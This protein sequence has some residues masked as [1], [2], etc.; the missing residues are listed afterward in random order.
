MYDKYKKIKIDPNA[1]NQDPNKSIKDVSKYINDK[2]KTVFSTQA[3]YN[4]ISNEAKTYEQ[5]KHIRLVSGHNC[6]P[7]TCVKEF[8]IARNNYY[9]V[10]DEHLNK[11]Q[12]P[13]QAYHLI[14][15]FKGKIDPELAHKIG[16][17]FCQILLGDSFQA[18]VST[19]LNTQ[20]THN[21]IL[22][23]AFALDGPYKFKDEYHLYKKLREISNSLSLKYGVELYMG[24]EQTKQSYKHTSWSE[25]ID[26]EH[27]SSYKQQFIEDIKQ[28]ASCESVK[29]Y[30][31]FIQEMESK[32][33][34]CSINKSSTT[35]KKDGMTFR[36]VSL[37][38]S[39]KKEALESKWQTDKQKEDTLNYLKKLREENA[40]KYKKYDTIFV[41][42]WDNL[43]NRLGILKR[44]LLMIK[45]LL[46]QIADD[47]YLPELEEMY[48]SNTNFQSA[49]K[50]LDNVNKAIELLTTYN[51]KTDEGLLIA[52]KETGSAA[53]QARAELNL[54]SEFLANAEEINQQISQFTSLQELL[55]KLNIPLDSIP[56]ST[57][58]PDE[59]KANLAS[60]EPM[61]PK[62]KSRLYQKLHA[63]PY[64]LAVPFSSVTNTEAKEILYFLTAN[65]ENNQPSIPTPSLLLTKE[66]YGA[67]LAKKDL[68]ELVLAKLNTPK[69]S[70]ILSSGNK[71][72][73]NSFVGAY[74]N[75][76]D[77]QQAQQNVFSL[78]HVPSAP[79][80]NP[81][82]INSPKP[83][84]SRPYRATTEQF[85]LVC[86]FKKAYPNLFENINPSLLSAK[87]AQKII[88]Y[89][90]STILEESDYFTSSSNT[91]SLDFTSFSP[92]IQELI[93]EYRLVKSSL[94]EYGLSS[95]SDIDSFQNL[96]K[97][98][99]REL[100]KHS[101]DCKN[102]SDKYKDLKFIQRVIQ[103]ASKTT[104]VYGAGYM[105][106]ASELKETKDS[107]GEPKLD[108]LFE[109]HHKLKSILS[110]TDLSA[111][112]QAP[113]SSTNFIPPTPEIKETLSSIKSV[114]PESYGTLNIDTISE[115]DALM[116][117]HSII[118][119]QEIELE[120]KKILEQEDKLESEETKKHDKQAFELFMQNQLN[121]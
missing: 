106:N 16:L 5:E 2:E 39:Y 78:L 4:Y 91:N 7:E 88:D 63:S 112:S 54:T 50:K 92:D 120:M 87:D 65:N 35:F 13:I 100:Q 68:K 15:S 84:Y 47:Y 82:P 43:G 101:D 107:L 77:S 31:S 62:V 14:S 71:P 55:L 58:S 95:Q 121:N 72:N 110:S 45:N 10:K 66:E 28:A 34:T 40:L 6:D 70:L 114:F 3:A 26:P 60:L 67:V 93:K 44:L 113:I 104:F 17:E 49:F 81:F 42:K 57:P 117:I 99:Q 41:P 11:G 19:H 79:L 109:M 9:A 59:I 52:L 30:P 32:G 86:Q 48:P 118:E 23:N 38:A 24:D 108:S 73:M 36:D 89:G 74:M 29:D 53:S 18:V 51:I 115:Y 27:Y 22:V 46:E 12:T 83:C 76:K 69:P 119:Q 90:V 20:N 37:G 111:L 61:T 85:K 75:K 105:G 33:Y 1:K 98:K 116:L 25:V 96:C 103:N 21:H 80:Q 64:R 97:D 8:E 56:L 102:I 94:L